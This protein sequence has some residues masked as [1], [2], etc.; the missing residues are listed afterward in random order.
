MIASPT[1]E[2][3]PTAPPIQTW[4]AQSPDGAWLVEGTRQEFLGEACEIHTSLTV[5]KVDGSNEWKVWDGKQ[6]CGLGSAN[7]QPFYWPTSGGDF[8]FTN[9]P[10]VDGCA[11]FVN[12]SDLYRVDLTTGEVTQ[13]VRDVGLSLALSPDETQLAYIAYGQRG[14][15]IRDLV[16]GLERESALPTNAQAGNLVWSPDASALAFTLDEQT[17]SGIYSIIRTDAQSFE[18]QTLIENDERGLETVS[19][20]DPDSIALVDKEGRHWWLEVKTGKLSPALG[21]P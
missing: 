5:K 2:P 10:M 7:P 3:K 17:C 4:S 6:N 20:L 16:S 19:W 9:V 8:Y 11:Q 15:V 14:L 12:G 18:R 13:I 21:M 1:P